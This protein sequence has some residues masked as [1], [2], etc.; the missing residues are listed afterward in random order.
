MTGFVS[1]EKEGKFYTI[2][3]IS[4]IELVLYPMRQDRMYGSRILILGS[5]KKL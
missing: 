4:K 5:M 2:L 1:R 3:K